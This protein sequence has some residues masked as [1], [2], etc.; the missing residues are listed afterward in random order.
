MSSQHR[1]RSPAATPPRKPASRRDFLRTLGAASALPL[2]G[3]AALGSASPAGAQPPSGAAPQP[4]TIPQATAETGDAA[5]ARSL[6]EIVR[7]RFGSQL[8]EAQLYDIRKDIEGS[9]AA[10]R[11]LRSLSLQ[12][13]DEPAIVFRALPLEE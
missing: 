11:R 9:L 12:N 13:A 2:V 7:R 1:K 4:A 8:T 10:G 5:D 3:A 6:S